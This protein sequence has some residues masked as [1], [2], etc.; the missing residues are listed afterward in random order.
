LVISRDGRRIVRLAAA[1]DLHVYE[2]AL[3]RWQRA[4]AALEGV[5]LVLLAGDLTADGRAEQAETLGVA[6]RESPAPVVAVLGNHDWHCGAQDEI[7]GALETAGVTVLSRT[8][9]SF[10]LEE[11]S[12]GV[13]GCK[14]FVG[15]FLDAR[16]PDFGEALLREV[17]AETG[18]DVDALDRGL[19]S[20]AACGVRVV[21]LHYAPTCSTLV[22]ER[23]T[24]WTFLGS[25]R[26]A[27]PISRHKP[28]LV[29]HGHAHGGTF[30]GSIG[31]VAVHNVALPVIRRDFQV[32]EVEPAPAEEEVRRASSSVR[33][34]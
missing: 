9:A 31:P 26:L 8:C 7:A 5:D 15:G 10:S 2:T 18:R 33:S 1:G 14:G 3:E 21:L 30:E 12:V 16:M 24:I 19:E 29:L 4:F 22:G 34:S 28:D 6:A 25:D 23:E 13:V 20:I 27:A 17:Y 11:T 32:F